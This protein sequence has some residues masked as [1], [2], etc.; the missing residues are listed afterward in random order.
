METGQLSVKEH[1][2]TL[3]HSTT[4][5]KTWP[6]SALLI[7]MYCLFVFVVD[8]ARMMH[9]SR[10]DYSISKGTDGIQS[11]KKETGHCCSFLTKSD[12]STEKRKESEV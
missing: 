7:K 6:K 4:E 3:H 8:Y 9:G 12:A 11:Q 5:F 2:R 10:H 1:K